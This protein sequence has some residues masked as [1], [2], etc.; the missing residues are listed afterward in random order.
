MKYLSPIETADLEG[1]SQLNNPN[2][3]KKKKNRT[4]VC[5]KQSRSSGNVRG[6]SPPPRLS[7]I[8]PITISTNID[9][10]TWASLCVYLGQPYK[11]LSTSRATNPDMKH[12]RG[13]VRDRNEKPA[14]PF[15]E[16]FGDCDRRYLLG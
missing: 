8:S 5:A 4:C 1:V 13:Y 6:P 16:L 2:P 14:V 12:V 7:T 3:K 10:A 11:I 15:N 9:C